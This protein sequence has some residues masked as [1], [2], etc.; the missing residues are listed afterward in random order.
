MENPNLFLVKSNSYD[1]W[2][3]LALEEYLYD[4]IPEQS[5]ILYLWQNQNTVV[6]GKSQ[7]AWKECRVSELEADGGK[8]ARRR[9]EAAPYSMTWATCAILSSPL[10]AYMT[11]KSSCA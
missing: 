5:V 9:P 11:R 8:L 4:S 6:I 1:P 7:N 10:P 3:N 2:F